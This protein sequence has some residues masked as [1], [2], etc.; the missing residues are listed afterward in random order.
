M[1]W[2]L[3]YYKSVNINLNVRVDPANRIYMKTS[4]EGYTNQDRRS[5][6]EKG[7]LK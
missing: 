5:T 6:Q 4:P 3:K 1:G 2:R 7:R